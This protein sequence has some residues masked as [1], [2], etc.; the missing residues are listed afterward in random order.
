MTQVQQ[1]QQVFA[2]REAVFLYAACTADGFV[3]VGISRTPYTRLYTIHCNSPSPVQAAQWAWVGSI[4]LGRKMERLIRA[5]WESRHTRGEWYRFDYSKIEDKAA[6][7]DTLNAIFEVVAG[8]KP[9]WH[10]LSPEKM[11]ELIADPLQS[12]KAKQ[13][14]R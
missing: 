9:E 10:K 13:A 7:H 3:K 14:A 8:N 12:Q 6:F 11:A 1:L 5:D 2:L 4:E